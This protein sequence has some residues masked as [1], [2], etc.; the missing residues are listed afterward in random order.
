MG[1]PGHSVDSDTGEYVEDTGP[2][3]D[4]VWQDGIGWSTIGHL[5]IVNDTRLTNG[6]GWSVSPEVNS[7]DD[8]NVHV[9]WVDGRSEEHSRTAPSQLHYM[10][11][12][13]SRA[14]PFDGEADGLDLSTVSAVSYTHLTLPTILLV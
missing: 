11:M 9:V 12:D 8:G 5:V 6:H 3:V 13:L 4:Y 7:D 2:S 10:Q 14:G 1:D